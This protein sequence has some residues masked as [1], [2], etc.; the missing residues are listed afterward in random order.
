MS[1]V[2]LIDG[3]EVDSSSDEWRHESEARAIAKLPSLAERRA[4]LEDIQRKRGKP[5][6]DRLRK[7]MTALWD[8]KGP[9]R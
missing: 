6:A 3:S 7:T 5:A 1:T 4:W 8:A 9:A 2:R